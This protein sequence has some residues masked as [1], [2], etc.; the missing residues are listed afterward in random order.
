[1][2]SDVKFL[3][4]FILSIPL[5]S[6][7]PHFGVISHL[8]SFCYHCDCFICVCLYTY[9]IAVS[10]G[11]VHI[12][13]GILLCLPVTSS[14]FMV[15]VKVYSHEGEGEGNEHLDSMDLHDVKSEL[16]RDAEKAEV[17]L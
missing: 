8:H 2:K 7:P 15:Q 6:V 10:I 9:G 12:E 16:E 14:V 4:D 17:S 1:M 5:F 3:V 13:G 11:G